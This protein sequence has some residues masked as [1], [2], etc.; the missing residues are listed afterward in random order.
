MTTDYNQDISNI[1]NE[2]KSIIFTICSNF[3]SN[4]INELT[5]ENKFS[6]IDLLLLLDDLMRSLYDLISLQLKQL[7]GEIEN[8]PN[9]K[10][11]I[12]RVLGGFKDLWDKN[13]ERIAS[14]IVK[15]QMTEKAIFQMFNQIE[16]TLKNTVT[17]QFHIIMK[18]ME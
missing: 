2:K 3:L 5:V 9:I 11:C 17:A 18:C 12:N 14:K 15:S 16:K 6:N 10:Y 4:T 7:P 13:L 8:I 1:F